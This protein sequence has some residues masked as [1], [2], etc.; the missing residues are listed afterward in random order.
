MI[1]KKSILLLFVMLMVLPFANSVSAMENSEGDKNIV[2][3]AKETGKFNTLVTALEKA[4]LVDTLQGDGPFTVFAP[5]D[6]AF[7]KLLK[8]LDITAEEL[9]AREDLKKILLYHVVPGKVMSG[10]LKDGMTVKTLVDKKVKILLNPVR[11]NKATVI[12]PDIEAS[13]GVIHVIDMVLLP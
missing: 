1:K 7:E 2:D 4:K 13:N 10:D 12:S 8:K 6:Q 9:L 3:I 5:T 11:V